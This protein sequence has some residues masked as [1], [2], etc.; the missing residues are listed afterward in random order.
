MSLVLAQHWQLELR[1]IRWHHFS[2]IARSLHR[3]R[4]CHR[5][6][7]VLSVLDQGWIAAGGVE[8]WK[9]GSIRQRL[10]HGVHVVDDCVLAVPIDSAGYRRKYE[11]L[12]GVH[13][14]CLGCGYRAVVFASPETLARPKHHNHRLR[15]GSLVSGGKPAIDRLIE[16]RELAPTSGGNLETIELAN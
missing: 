6:Y 12:W 3:V 15:V 8:S 9:M 11:L 14:V 13:G 1:S 5:L 7:A 4:N 16:E 2:L 10:R